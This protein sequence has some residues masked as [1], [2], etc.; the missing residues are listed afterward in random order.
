[1]EF[2]V[3]TLGNHEFDEGGTEML[4]LIRGGHREDGK[5]F[6][7][8]TDTSDPDFPGADYPYVSA[9]VWRRHRPPGAAAVHGHQARG[10]PGRDHRRDDDRD[11]E[12]RRPRRR[13][14]LQ[15]LR[16]QRLGE[17]A[18]QGPAPHGRPHDRRAGPRGRL[19]G[20]RQGPRGRGADRGQAD[21][22]RRRPRR[23]RPHP[24]LPQH[25]GQQRAGR[26]G[27]QVRHR[28]RAGQAD[29]RPAHHATSPPRQRDVVTT[30]DDGAHAGAGPRALV[31]TFKDRIAPVAQR[32]WA[33]RRPR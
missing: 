1:M 2:D 7:D 9:N 33:P 25:Q 24:Q 8:G 12:H 11:A 21:G 3:G 10:H 15:V 26:A 14:A 32:S 27:L 18:G 30:Y 5:Q 23:R 19:P 20:P 28:L 22:P 31:Q 29:R 4:R 13:R 17:P 16:P 6:K